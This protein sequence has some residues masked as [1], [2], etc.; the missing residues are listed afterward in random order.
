M[1][2]QQ[3]YP[4]FKSSGVAWLGDIPEH[5]QT[6][7]FKS[8]IESTINGVWGDEPKQDENDFV[9]VRVA[10]FC[11]DKLTISDQNL[12][13][14]NIE[15]SQQCSR[16]LEQ[17]DLLIEKSGGGDTQPVGRVVKVS[18]NEQAVCSNFIARL[19]TTNVIDNSFLAYVFYGAYSVS[20][21]TRA[22]K[23]TTG[24]QNLDLYAYLCENFAL[25][26][27][28]EQKK[29]VDFLNRE[30]ATIDTLIAKKQQLIQ[31]LQKQRMALISHAVTK[32]LDPRVR[33]KESGVEWIGKMPAHWELIR[34]K[35]LFKFLNSRRIPLSAEERGD[36]ERVY[37]YY[38]ASGII[39]HVDSYLF[40][41]SLILVAEDGANLFS[42][43]T[44]LAFIAEGKYW[45]NNHAHILRP[46]D[47]RI[48]Y[49]EYVLTTIEYDPWITGSAQPKL[50]I[51]NLG[52][53]VLPEPPDDEKQ[54]ITNYLNYQISALDTLIVKTRE[55]I[56][57]IQKYRTTLISSAVTGKIDVRNR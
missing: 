29:I 16:S 1:M 35:F 10:D 38:G 45:V 20:L 47:S 17:G 19:V 21:N 24:I 49:W 6:R 40:D 37:P 52:S 12:T 8:V 3:K 25:P 28:D 15:P 32:G 50:T 18:L 43:S 4:N 23:Q 11:Y 26:P 31:A 54:L 34:L 48:K 51:E 46:R 57:K 39:D 55:G 41:E 9:C 5:W 13:L 27:I 22:I 44:P 42:K 56:D 14:R 53:I 30:T 36:M 7:R 33:M 2:Q